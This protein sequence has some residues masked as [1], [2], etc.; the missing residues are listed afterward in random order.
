MHYSMRAC[1]PAGLSTTGRTGRWP[2][3]G[4]LRAEVGVVPCTSVLVSPRDARAG[5]IT[6]SQR[7]TGSYE[8]GSSSLQRQFSAERISQISV[9]L[10][11][12]FIVI[13]L[14]TY[15]SVVIAKLFGRRM[16][17]VDSVYCKVCT[18]GLRGSSSDRCPECGDPIPR[19]QPISSVNSASTSP[20]N[21]RNTTVDSA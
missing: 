19:D 2:F 4:K 18:Y 16:D 12:W 5:F 15:P 10:P 21:E 6:A 14:L 9:E 3:I 8:T 7:Q 13:V 1:M 11:T 20:V 17:V